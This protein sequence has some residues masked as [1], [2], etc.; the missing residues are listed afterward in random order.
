MKIIITGAA[1]QDGRILG[2][3][4]KASGHEVIMLSRPSVSNQL[5]NDFPDL[6]S[7]SCDLTKLDELEKILDIEHPDAIVNLAAFS[8]VKDSWKNPEALR[9]INI[10]LPT[11]MLEWMRKRSQHTKLVQAS[12]SE[13]FGSVS[14][15]PQ[16]EQTP[17]RPLTPYGHS[18]AI[19][20]EVCI[21]YRE[22]HKLLVSNA[23]LYNHESLHRSNKYVTHHISIGVASIKANKLSKLKIGNI[24][25][26]RDWGWADEY[27]RGLESLLEGG[28]KSDYVFASGKTHSVE[29]LLEI[30]FTSAG[31]S[32][33]RSHIEITQSELRMAD[34][35]NLCGDSSKARKELGW[36]PKVKVQDFLPAM[37]RNDFEL[38]EKL[39][40]KARCNLE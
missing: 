4:L 29:D 36:E 22:K 21:N 16:N 31:I 32:D 9:K 12:S 35:V 1:G 11:F 27:M 5:Q 15:E 18:K 8:S 40:L 2:P 10:D 24:S 20:H 7:V 30:G 23:I 13:I 17:L 14:M 6:K 19:A 28:I 3:K 33:Y 25:A 37:I 38:I 39:N 34:P 26:R